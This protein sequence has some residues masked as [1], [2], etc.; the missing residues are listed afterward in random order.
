MIRGISFEIPN[1]YGSYLAGI[2]KP[3]DVAAYNWYVGGEEAYFIEDGE[4]GRPLFPD[5]VI[6]MEGETLKQTIE[7]NEYYVIFT[8]LKAFPRNKEII[9]I[10]T[11][12]DFIISECSLVIL[13]VDCVYVTVYSKD[14]ETIQRLYNNSLKMG[15]SEVNFITD[16]NDFRTRLSVW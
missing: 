2:L 12:E 13:V 10:Q 6:G 7:K 5:E 4:L 16:E 3:V 9:D 8:N 11:F 1:E 15:F 14:P